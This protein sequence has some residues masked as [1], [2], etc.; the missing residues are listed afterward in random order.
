MNV[1]LLPPKKTAIRRWN[2]VSSIRERIHK[3][4]VRACKEK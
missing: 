2:H 1:S 4:F 3:T